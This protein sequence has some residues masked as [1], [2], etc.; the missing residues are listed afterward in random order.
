MHGKIPG[1]GHFRHRQMETSLHIRV[2]A[3]KLTANPYIPGLL[4]LSR[5]CVGHWEQS[6]PSMFCHVLPITFIARMLLWHQLLVEEYPGIVAELTVMSRITSALNWDEDSSVTC[7]CVVRVRVC[8]YALMHLCLFV[9][10]YSCVCMRVYAYLL[11]WLLPAESWKAYIVC[12]YVCMH[13]CMSVCLSICIYVC[14]PACMYASTYLYVYAHASRCV[15]LIQ[16]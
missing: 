13:V 12:M 11:R 15:L 5:A 1:K 6:I 16:L 8:K 7:V 3:S 2:H 10:L 4:I 14:L 9:Y